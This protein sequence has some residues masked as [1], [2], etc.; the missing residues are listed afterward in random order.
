MKI[1]IIGKSDLGKA[2][3]SLCPEHDVKIVGRPE[4][5][6]LNMEDC[7][8][9]V[10]N[11]DADCIILT[12]G[13]VNDINLWNMFT[14][15]YTSAVY[16]ISEFYNKMLS[17]QIIV[18][19]S[20][21]VNWKSWPGIEINRLAYAT[22]KGAVSDFC[23]QMNRKNMPGNSE[24]NISIQVYEPN[25]FISKLNNTSKL[26]TNIVAQELLSLV[27]NPRISVLQ[28]LNR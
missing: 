14:L 11:Y 12:Q 27:N 9:I 3:M 17:G 24:K 8:K 13:S 25:N 19:S 26:D 10:D 22:A 4:Y 23:Q 28:G 7:K 5:N 16:L 6:L 2:L 20:A 18:V 15:N 21:T 1:L